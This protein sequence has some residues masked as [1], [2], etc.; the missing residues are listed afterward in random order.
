MFFTRRL[1]RMAAIIMLLIATA[2][3]LKQSAPGCRK[4][5]L[6]RS[7][8]RAIEAYGRSPLRFEANEGQFDARAK[9][10]SRN[11]GYTL[12]LTS[13]E[14]A[15]NLRAAEGEEQF[16]T[17]RMKFVNANPNPR[18]IGMERMAGVSNYFTGGD[19][20]R[21]RAN[22]AN[23]A[24]VKS[25]DVWPGIDLVWYGVQRQL[26]HDF[27]VAPGADP[28]EI[29]LEFSGA[30]EMSV[31][32][33]GALKLRTD[34]GDLR[35][36]RP[37]AWQAAGLG[38]QEVACDY[39]INGARQVEFR[40]GDYDR[41]KELVIDPVI[42]LATWF[43][44]TDV[45]EAR[46]L[47]VDRDGA[48]YIAGTTLSIDFP[49]ANPVQQTRAASADAFALKLSL[50]GGQVV[51]ATYLGGGGADQ[52]L[53]IAVDTSGAAYIA[54]VTTSTDFPVTP[55]ASQTSFN[56][57]AD[58]FVTKLNANG[59]ALVWSS[60]L[61]G[62]GVD[63]AND[64]AV[65]AA[66]N[67]HLTGRT[68][69]TDLPAN[70]FQTSRGGSPLYRSSN[71]GGAWNPSGAGLAG[72]TTYG[73]TVD[74]ANSNVIY[75]ATDLGLYKSVDGGARWRATAFTGA[76]LDVAIDL[77]NTATIY[78]AAQGL[79]AK[80]VNGG[81]SF[82]Q[83]ASPQNLLGSNFVYTVVVDPQA[84][85][86]VYAGTERAAFKSVDGGE[87]WTPSFLFGSPS[88][89]VRV[90]RL[91]VDPNNPPAIFAGTDR[92]VF[93][94]ANAGGSWSPVLVGAALGG[95]SGS[96]LFPGIR[97][98]AIDPAQTATIYAGLNNTG[99]VYKSTNGG[100][101][102]SRSD[103]GIGAVNQVTLINALAIS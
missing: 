33:E 63:I 1:A 6:D 19:P 53:S 20:R 27:I 60:L 2:P 12:F 103:A 67:V 31:D 23:F 83:Q 16:A 28:R 45:D 85:A 13:D 56:G 82:T 73:L 49:V 91:V 4:P 89:P 54:G 93:K 3:E 5:G 64:L 66:G 21:W 25:Q 42:T 9:F 80:S 29:R 77:R 36:L 98:L 75:A 58:G 15:I 30:R 48:A 32:G 78:V 74:P 39:R 7:V 68:T 71:S 11:S 17:V 92:G 34:A 40:L 22:V 84:P 50:D 59:S 99:S 10:I 37:V 55:G 26:E 86:T 18:V 97:A 88:A 8:S 24:K 62:D 47:A 87:T 38:R 96:S 35:L 14:A 43:G 101:T 69:S 90:T 76:A 46:N 79:L 100:M 65:D 61:G 94:S 52:A 81:E 41:D 44:G 72:T 57:V 51:Y 95:F 70:G 102:W